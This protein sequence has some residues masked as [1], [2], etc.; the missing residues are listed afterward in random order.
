[1]VASVQRSAILCSITLAAV[2]C[3]TAVDAACGDHG[4]VAPL[5]LG[6]LPIAADA[7]DLAKARLASAYLEFAYS[8][9]SPPGFYLGP[10]SA[11]L[12]DIGS[13]ILASITGFRATTFINCM[14]HALVISIDHINV[15]EDPGDAIGGILRLFTRGNSILALRFTEFVMTNY[16]DYYITVVGHSAGGGIASYAAGLYGLPS[17]TYNSART[18]AARTND[19]AQQLNVIVRGD[20]IADPRNSPRALSGLTLFV[21]AG[22]FRGSLHSREALE[23]GLRNV[24]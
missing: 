5:I 3:A 7:S 2:L 20:W 11:D 24:R 8:D 6:R 18:P 14:S 17:I 19:G 12:F 13:K 10:N 4:P 16:P 21:D 23:I 22:S 1:M 15:L 9:S